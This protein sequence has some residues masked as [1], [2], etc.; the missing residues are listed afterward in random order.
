MKI[1]AVVVT[2]NRLSLLQRTIACLRDSQP[3]LDAIVV[4]N[5]DSSDGTRQWLDSQSGLVVIHQDNV[6][7]AGGFRR[8]MKKAHEMGA[9]WVWC[10]DDDVFPRPDCLSRFIDNMDYAGVGIMSP[11]R[12]VEGEIFTTE[13]QAFDLFHTMAST[14]ISPLRKMQVDNTVEIA[15][16]AFE[17]LFIKRDVIDAIGYPNDRLFIFY[18]DTDY[19]IRTLQAGFKL[20]YV[21]QALMDKQKFFSNVTWL[22]RTRAK[23]WKRFYQVRNGSWFHHRYGKT[24]GVRNIRPF[25]AMLGY[26]VPALFLG[27]FT[28]A[29]R[30]GDA[31]RFVRA[32]R[33]GRRE[34]LGRIPWI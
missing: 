11:R 2:F 23:R 8:G 20:I 16:A 32:Y 24:W 31:A 3:A 15:G 17:G 19:C 21:P 14:S 18:D 28:K 26:M 30:A 10:M 22:E 4:V 6:G 5:N 27:L 29:Y 1:I 25:N 13:F 7:G 12:L 33:E 34:Q 9:D